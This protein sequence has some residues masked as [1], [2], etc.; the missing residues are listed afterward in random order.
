MG[1]IVM[2]LL[3]AATNPKLLTAG[4]LEGA[5]PDVFRHPPLDIPEGSDLADL[6]ARYNE[7]ETPGKFQELGRLIKENADLGRKTLG[8]VKFCT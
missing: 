8:L 4:S 5:D 3:E 6:I 7:Y 1:R 2:Y